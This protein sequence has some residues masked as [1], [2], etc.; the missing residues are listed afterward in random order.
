MINII[1]SFFIKHNTSVN[2]KGIG[3]K[4]YPTR[5]SQVGLFCLA[6]NPPDT[7]LI[8]KIKKALGKDVQFII[9]ALG[10]NHGIDNAYTL[11]R[12]A[13]DLFGKIKNTSLSRDLSSLDMLI[14]MTQELS[15]VKNYAISIASQAYKISVGQYENNIY[16]LSILLEPNEF[17]LLGDEIIKYHKILG[18]GE[19]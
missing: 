15:F 18:N 4:Y 13:F 2:Q 7:N 11:D 14:D 5:F 1:K 10:K 16:N 6:H 8:T 9:F 12:K 19:S 17:S 3:L